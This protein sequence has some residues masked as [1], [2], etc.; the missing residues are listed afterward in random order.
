M[1]TKTFQ[2]GT[3]IGNACRIPH[4]TESVPVALCGRALSNDYKHRMDHTHKRSSRCDHLT[5]SPPFVPVLLSA[6]L[7]GSLFGRRWMERTF[8][9]TP[10]R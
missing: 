6:L 7:L 9:R 5:F 4:S 2:I 8:S 1:S 3:S 10:R